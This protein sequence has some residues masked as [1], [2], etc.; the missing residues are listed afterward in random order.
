MSQSYRNYLVQYL[1]DREKQSDMQIGDAMRE[2][3]DLRKS[4]L[5]YAGLTLQETFSIPPK[6]Q[7]DEGI[8][9]TSQDGEYD[10]LAMQEIKGTRTFLREGETVGQFSVDGQYHAYL[11]DT[12]QDV[13]VIRSAFG[14]YEHVTDIVKDE[15]AKKTVR[16]HGR[17]VLCTPDGLDADRRAAGEA[18]DGCV[19]CCAFFRHFLQGCCL[20]GSTM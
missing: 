20:L 18:V 6:G 3:L 17:S 9:G 2:V 4:R 8:I 5:L 12:E 11:T 15:R 7:S 16:H 1:T 13:P 10:C 19:D 14:V